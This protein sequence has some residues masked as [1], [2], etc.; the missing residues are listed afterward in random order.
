MA[1]IELDNDNMIRN[2]RYLPSE[3]RQKPALDMAEQAALAGVP[4][5]TLEKI[6]SEEGGPRLFMLGRHRKAL[7]EDF[8][9]WLKRRASSHPYVRQ[10]A[11]NPNGRNGKATGTSESETD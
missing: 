7:L 6:Y 9:D 1:H 3:I 10:P 5:S 11:R 8:M 4:L 2:S